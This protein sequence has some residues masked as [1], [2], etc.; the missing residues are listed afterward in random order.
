ME[1][2]QV[3]Y[4][5]ALARSLNFTRAAEACSVSQPALTKGVQRLEQELGSPL[6]YRERQLTHLTDLGRELLPM[7]EDMLASQTLIQGR[8][9]EFTQREIAQLKIGL[10]PS[11]S[12]SLLVG[13]LRTLNSQ[14]PSLQVELLEARCAALL[15]MLLRGDIHAALVG[16]LEVKPSR[17]DEW[18]LFEERYVAVL[19]ANH[20]LANRPKL[21]ATDLQSTAILR[22]A[23]CDLDSQDDQ[24]FFNTADRTTSSPQESHLQHLAAAGFGIILAPEHMPRLSELVSVPLEA[25]PIT[26]QVRLLVVQGRKYSPALESFVKIMRMQDWSLAAKGRPRANDGFCACRSVRACSG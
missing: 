25:D 9:R 22:R 18:V 19:S 3:K 5:V 14:F 13:P 6:I 26:R 15:D 21:T 24:A 17:I 20:G 11:V 4:F 7:F 23:H 12:A 10:V 1:L 16:G 2:H 8:A